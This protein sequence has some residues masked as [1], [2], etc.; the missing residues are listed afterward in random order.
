PWENINSGRIAIPLFIRLN[1]EWALL[2]IPMASF[3]AAE[4]AN[5]G[6]SFSGGGIAGFIYKFNDNLSIGP[7]LGVMSAIEDN[8][9]IFPVLLIKWQISE[10]LLLKTGKGIGAS[11]G[12]G[13]FLDWQ[14]SEKWILSTG[15]R[16]EKL[17]FRLDEKGEIP[18][19]VG[20]DR[21]FPLVGSASYS[22]TENATLSVLTGLSLFG[23]LELEDSNGDRIEKENYDPVF[24]LGA[25]FRLKM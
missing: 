15:A 6:D 4:G 24:L 3:H 10:T 1:E 13:V 16:Y 11:L 17:R 2:G 19:G 23:K 22:I 8:P 7:G 9:T 20:E 5:L 12:P 18:D 21:S 25:S 14:A